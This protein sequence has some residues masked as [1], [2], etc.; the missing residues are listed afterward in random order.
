MSKLIKKGEDASLE[1]NSAS[2]FITVFSMAG[3]VPIPPP[4]TYSKDYIRLGSRP[5]SK[6]LCLDERRKVYNHDIISILYIRD[7][8]YGQLDQKNREIELWHRRMDQGC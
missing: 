8:N 5:H 1:E 4:S 2:S 7:K 6:T 3:G